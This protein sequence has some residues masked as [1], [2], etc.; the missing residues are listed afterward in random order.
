ML[1]AKH[2]SNPGSVI[3]NFNPHFIHECLFRES[4]SGKS[5][6]SSSVLK[7]AFDALSETHADLQLV[8]KAEKA[9][10]NDLARQLAAAQKMIDALKEVAE[11]KEK[12]ES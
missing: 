6:S 3:Q 8:S 10:S 5:A 7:N 4:A 9:R 11:A 1:G 12:I 2:V